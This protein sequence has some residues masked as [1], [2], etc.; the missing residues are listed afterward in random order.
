MEANK[1]SV[2]RGR[3]GVRGDTDDASGL[4]VPRGREIH[5]GDK[6]R[7]RLSHIILCF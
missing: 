2:S 7:A 1:R 6:V 4:D 3:E 5:P